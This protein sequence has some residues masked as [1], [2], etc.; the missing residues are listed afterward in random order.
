MLAESLAKLEIA[1]LGEAE[2]PRRLQR[3]K[4]FA[5][6]FDEHGQFSRD[7]VIFADRQRS[8]LPDEGL[9]TAVQFHHCASWQ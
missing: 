9:C 4:P 5:L 1:L 8:L 3:P 7:F 6:A 2:L